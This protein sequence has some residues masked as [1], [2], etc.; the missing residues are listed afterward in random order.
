M[1]TNQDRNYDMIYQNCNTK[2]KYL[3]FFSYKS[4]KKQIAK[5]IREVQKYS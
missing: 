1:R 2:C 5:N 4:E 3:Y